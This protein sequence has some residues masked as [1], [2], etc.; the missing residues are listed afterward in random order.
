MSQNSARRQPLS[1]NSLHVPT[2][3]EQSTSDLASTGWFED[4]EVEEFVVLIAAE[5]IP[6][7]DSGKD[8]TYALDALVTMV[9]GLAT[10]KRPR[11]TLGQDFVLE[12]LFHDY[13]NLHFDIPV[14]Q[15]FPHADPHQAVDAQGLAQ[16]CTQLAAADDRERYPRIA[17]LLRAMAAR[18]AEHYEKQTP[19]S[20]LTPQSPSLPPTTT[21]TT[22]PL[23][24]TSADDDVTGSQQAG[25]AQP[26][27][28][29]SEDSEFECESNDADDTDNDA[30]KRS[31]TSAEKVLQLKLYSRQL[32]VSDN[33]GVSLTDTDQE[34]AAA[35]PPAIAF[36]P[37]PPRQGIPRASG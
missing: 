8:L 28:G 9:N 5:A 27:S 16:R 29:D 17:G 11:F 13:L 1:T 35:P 26:S 24:S 34:P 25:P 36:S 33:E 3:R 32:Q 6:R 18:C 19:P 10:V 12:Q 22:P 14:A 7:L 15:F 30:T 4:S 21:T 31:N 23:S 20:I 37:L 2:S